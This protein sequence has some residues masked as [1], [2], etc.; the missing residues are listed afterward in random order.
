[1]K[2]SINQLRVG[3]IGA[4][5][6]GKV[7]LEGFKRNKH[8][9]LVAIASRTEEHANAFAKKFDIPQ[10][11]MGEGWKDMLNNENLDIVSIC[12]PNYLHY[13]MIIK[14]LENNIH[15]LCEKPVCISQKEL[16][17]VE[18]ELSKKD[19]MFFTAFHKRYISIFPIIKKIIDNDSLGK[20]SLVRYA[21]AHLGPYISH[22]ALSKEKWF[23]DSGKAGGGVFLDLGV[24]SIDIFRYLIGD[25]K[26]IE[27][28]NYNTTCTEMKDEDNCNVLVRFQN[29][30]LGIISVSWCTHP[31]ELIEIFGT[32]GSIS[33]DLVS[34]NLFNYKPETLKKNSFI[35]EAINHSISKNVPHHL[36]IDHFIQC[37]L[38]KKNEN[39]NF[40]DGKRAVEFILEAYAL[41]K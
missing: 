1:V 27:G 36:L 12:S 11:F 7:H 35:Y 40:E 6:I 5:A 15:I 2:N 37:I 31:T 23:F 8:C 14:S 18:A 17:S 20:I 9:K 32:K 33:I 22:N 39:P 19:L 21:F 16:D 24:H 41:K 26:N 28:F 13:P 3:L 25:Y 29:E 30:V 4:G 34:N 10:T 38:Q